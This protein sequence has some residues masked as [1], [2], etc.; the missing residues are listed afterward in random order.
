MTETDTMLL[1]VFLK[2]DQSKNLGEIGAALEATGFWAAMPPE[3]VTIESWYVMMGIGFVITLRLAP[4]KLRAVNLV[5][6]RT[7][8]GAFRSEF[9]PTYDYRTIAEGKRAE[10]KG[11]RKNPT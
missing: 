7:A 2:H 8:W 5:I 11:V 3:G 1:T 4:D 10:V 6:E 9:Y